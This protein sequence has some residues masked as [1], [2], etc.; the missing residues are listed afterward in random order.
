M[1]LNPLRDKNESTSR[2]KKDETGPW[3]RF[4]Q[5]AYT[6]R[7]HFFSVFDQVVRSNEVRRHAEQGKRALSMV[8]DGV[9]RT[10]KSTRYQ[11]VRIVSWVFEPRHQIEAR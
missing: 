7:W 10:K 9:F 11:V 3:P 8:W 2:R 4:V 6:L 5:K 1:I